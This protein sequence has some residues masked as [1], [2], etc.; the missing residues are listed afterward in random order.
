MPPRS[1]W[2][3]RRATLCLLP[4]TPRLKPRLLGKTLTLTLTLTLIGG[5]CAGPSHAV[6]LRSA[7]PLRV[8]LS[9]TVETYIE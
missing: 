2:A 7:S 3:G 1:A 4:D 9:G 8:S 6:A 5:R